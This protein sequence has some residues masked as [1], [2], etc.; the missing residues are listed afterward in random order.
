MRARRLNSDNQRRSGASTLRIGALH[1]YTLLA[2]SIAGRHLAIGSSK[3]GISYSDSQTIYLPEG[4]HDRLMVGLVVQAALFAAGSLEQKV[5]KR[6]V[7]RERVARRYLTLEANRAMSV[8]GQYLPRSFRARIAA[9]WQGTMADDP[10]DSLRRALSRE[11]IPEAPELFGAIHCRLL[12]RTMASDEANDTDDAGDT[13]SE[14]DMRKADRQLVKRD[15]DNA[16][17]ED[18]E[19]S[20]VLKLMSLFAAF[21]PLSQL[22]GNLFGFKG[23]RGSR[24]KGMGGVGGDLGAG[25][26]RQVNGASGYAKPMPALL[27]SSDDVGDSP[28]SGFFYPEWDWRDRCHR[29]DWCCISQF[30]PALEENIGQLGEVS[31]KPLLRSM[32]RLGASFERHGHQADGEDLD[33]AALMDFVV[34]AASGNSGDER[35][36]ETRRKTRR[37]LGVILLLDT[38]GST[39]DRQIGGASIWDAQRILVKN[40]IAALEQVG[41]RVAAYGFQS[42]GRHDVRF[43][44]IKEFDGRFDQAARKRL[45]ALRPSGYTR[46]GAAI[47]HATEIVA[48]RSGAANQILVVVSDGY[49]FDHDYEANYAEHD[50][51]HALGEAEARG[52]GCV[53]LNVGA[54]TDDALLERV[55]GNVGHA[56][57]TGPGELGVH[58]ESLFRAA[59]QRVTTGVGATSRRAGERKKSGVGQQRQTVAYAALRRQQSIGG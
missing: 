6:L 51:R 36:Y 54:A 13:L 50:V 16:D 14:T 23:T 48:A 18:A 1:R 56:T 28:H 8:V 58:A 17:E 2:S 38:S 4:D 27:E 33:L 24:S 19:S 59:M 42:F 37:D 29:P 25:A 22:F 30:D 49:P 43:L 57:L 41:D 26:A 32:A 20:E 9:H 53:C 5:I 21:N 34:D 35:V 45:R 3:S 46:L 52:V 31:D 47:R 40:T 11:P 10:Q 44:R 12:L 7:G 15:L 39:S 55:W